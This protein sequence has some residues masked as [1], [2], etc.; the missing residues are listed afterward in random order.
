MLT[1]RIQKE[2]GDF[3][4]CETGLLQLINKFISVSLQLHSASKNGGH[5][6]PPG[7]DGHQTERI[8]NGE[9]TASGMRQFCF[10]AQFFNQIAIIQYS[11]MLQ[12]QQGTDG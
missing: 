12:F 2:R 6:S 1:G 5:E 4:R 7:W 3:F 11:L 8:G 10:F 9:L